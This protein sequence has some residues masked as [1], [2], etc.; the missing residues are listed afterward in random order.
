MVQQELGNSVFGVGDIMA[1]L[2]GASSNVHDLWALAVNTWMLDDD[3]L[4]IAFEDEF[5]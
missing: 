5:S 2:F 4:K 1:L 3:W